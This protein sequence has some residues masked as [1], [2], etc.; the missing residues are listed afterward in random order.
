[1]KISSNC[2]SCAP[3]CFSLCAQTRPARAARRRTSSIAAVT[4]RASPFMLE[5]PVGAIEEPFL[6]G[7]AWAQD[8]IGVVAAARVRCRL[9]EDIFPPHAV[10]DLHA[11]GRDRETRPSDAVE[12]IA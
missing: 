11:V 6:I 4:M 2:L 9:A 10:V 5:S 8:L 12:R 3:V 1:M 7:D